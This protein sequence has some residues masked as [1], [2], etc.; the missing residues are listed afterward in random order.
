MDV[1][2]MGT[3][4]FAV[5]SLR[6]LAA[7]HRVRAVYTRPDAV[8]RRGS[9][10]VAPPVKVIAEKLGLPV[11]Q[12]STLRDSAE[13]DRLRALAPDVI[14]VAAYGMILPS[15][16][17]AIPRFGCINVHASLLPRY[18]GAAPIHRAI[19]EG[20]TTL[21][22]SIMLMEEGLDT[23]PYALQRSLPAGDRTV[24][25]L[26]ALLAEEGAQ[27]LLEVLD[28]LES[29][30][31][32]WTQQDESQATYAAK[33]TRSDVA[34]RPDCTVAEALRRVRVSTRQAPSRLRVGD[35]DL[36]VVSASVSDTE[37]AQGSVSAGSSGLLIGV[38]DG[39]L[40]LDRIRPAGRSDMDG[41]AWVCGARLPATC[42]W[43]APL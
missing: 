38:R 35:M 28:T 4:E 25:E 34:L 3:P 1:V 39:S 19:L 30:T 17:L 2:F 42:T 5:P 12:P 41:V 13:T 24:P 29:G 7:S 20:E 32:S 14:C 31:V 33:I 26:T 23:G 37:L 9:A 10:L 16:I 36:T 21:G 8:S 43:K 11:V 6:V 27:A 15:D 18:R 22:V 40:S